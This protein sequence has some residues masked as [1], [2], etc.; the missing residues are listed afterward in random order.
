MC[1]LTSYNNKKDEVYKSNVSYYSLRYIF[2][3][4]YLALDTLT[5]RDQV[6]DIHGTPLDFSLLSPLKTF[7]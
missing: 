6:F 7:C 1:N 4:P 3:C 5:K 2:S